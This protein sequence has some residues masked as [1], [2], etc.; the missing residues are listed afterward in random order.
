MENW[1]RSL[2]SNPHAID[3]EIR[4]FD[5]SCTD[6]RGNYRYLSFHFP[7]LQSKAGPSPLCM[8]ISF[9]QESLMIDPYTCMWLQDGAAELVR[10]HWGLEVESNKG[11]GGLPGPQ[12]SR[13]DSEIVFYGS[14]C[15]DNLIQ[16]PFKLETL[17]LSWF[18]TFSSADN[19]HQ[20]FVVI[21][22]SLK[23]ACALFQYLVNN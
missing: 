21:A 9:V 1:L 2:R 12:A 15:S 18:C 5:R 16:L 3:S 13:P 11:I 6:Y 8:Q 14:H 23:V 7:K 19:S 17:T 4:R 10:R 22:E 20:R